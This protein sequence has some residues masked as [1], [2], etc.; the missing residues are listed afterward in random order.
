M[1][2]I[3]ITLSC[4]IGLHAAAAA[5]PGLVVGGKEIKAVD[6]DA[7]KAV[8]MAFRVD[9]RIDQASFDLPMYCMHCEGIVLL[10]KEKI[11]L[12][13]PFTAS[14]V[15]IPLANVKDTMHID[16]KGAL[17]PGTYYIILGVEKGRVILHNS[18][19]SRE[20]KET[21]AHRLIDMQADQADHYPSRSD[22]KADLGSGIHYTVNSSVG[23]AH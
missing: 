15:A 17:E 10:N 8:A 18:G 13:T 1:N 21:K 14:V 19:R 9:Q 3:A 4:L 5:E 11:G 23:A 6:V 16:V 7:G 20:V 22:F 2:K 12:K